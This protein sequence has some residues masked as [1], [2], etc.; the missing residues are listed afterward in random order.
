MDSC[1][2]LQIDSSNDIAEQT[3][4]RPNCRYVYPSSERQLPSDEIFEMDVTETC[5]SIEGS[6]WQLDAIG[7]NETH[8]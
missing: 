4:G 8:N 1:E 5:E 3:N 2:G 6:A 7:F